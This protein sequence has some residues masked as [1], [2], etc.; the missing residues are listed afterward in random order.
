MDGNYPGMTKKESAE[1]QKVALELIR[2]IE[3]LT[4]AREKLLYLHASDYSHAIG[5]LD[6]DRKQR[7]AELR[8]TESFKVIQKFIE[9]MG[10]GLV[11]LAAA[12]GN[13]AAKDSNS[14]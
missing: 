8:H 2:Q 1:D 11:E 9:G 4:K 6:D 3:D 12:L 10:M 14:G 13:I 7:W 5:V